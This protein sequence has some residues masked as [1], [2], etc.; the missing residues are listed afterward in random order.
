MDKVIE[1]IEEGLPQNTRNKKLKALTQS[2][3]KALKQTVETLSL[4][5]RK[6]VESLANEMDAQLAKDEHLD[7]EITDNF[8]LKILDDFGNE[9]TDSSAGF[10]MIALSFFYGLK[11][12]TA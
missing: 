8:G 1:Q 11:E 10:Q 2:I 4:E 3:E 5:M 9:S 7:F 6:S 12:S